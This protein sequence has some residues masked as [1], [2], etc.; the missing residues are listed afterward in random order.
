MC[1]VAALYDG[2]LAW[3]IVGYVCIVYNSGCR[4][5]GMLACWS[6]NVDFFA[7]LVAWITLCRFTA[8]LVCKIVG[9]VVK[10]ALFESRPVGI[11]GLLECRFVACVR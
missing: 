6:W 2:K 8:R 3:R 4:F 7:L 9:I 11:V 10:L 1:C 5:V